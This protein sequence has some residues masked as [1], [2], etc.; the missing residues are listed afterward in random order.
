[1]FECSSERR[2][3]FP[4]RRGENKMKIGLMC[5]TTAAKTVSRAILV[6]EDCDRIFE[7]DTEFGKACARSCLR[8]NDTVVVRFPSHFGESLQE[9]AAFFSSLDARDLS[10]HIL[11]HPNVC[12]RS[13]VPAMKT[14]LQ[15]GLLPASSMP[16]I[17]ERNH[18]NEN[19]AV[20]P[21]AERL[22]DMILKA[23][24][25]SPR[26]PL[27]KLRSIV[28][29]VTLGSANLTQIAKKNEVSLA[30]VRRYAE[31]ARTLKEV[32]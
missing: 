3:I 18:S 14:L 24:P 29:D 5:G 13:V 12:P 11:S 16:V 9:A 7:I 1:M 20:S 27:A 4:H 26:I 30:T 21:A 19:T 25:R 17:D 6:E 23:S 28:N 2:W 15:L 32:A 31:A 8:D 22:T 10:V